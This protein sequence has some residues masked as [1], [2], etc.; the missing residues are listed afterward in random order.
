MY[1]EQFQKKAQK[2]FENDTTKLR[3][4]Y[5]LHK[6]GMSRPE[7]RKKL[8]TESIGAYSRLIETIE[9]GVPKASAKDLQRFINRH[10]KDFSA[11][12]IQKLERL[13]TECDRR[14]NKKSTKSKK[15]TSQAEEA[16]EKSDIAGIYVYTYPKYY[17]HP[18]VPETND[19]DA[20]IYLKIGMSEKGAFK[21]VMQQKT[22]MPE[23]PKTLQIWK[24]END[25]D[26]RE[27]E[28]K[29]HDHLR[30]IGHGG[31]QRKEWF[32]T[33]E[34][35]VESIANLLGLRLHYKHNPEMDD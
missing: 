23:E 16:L 9:T 12:D 7:I 24:V 30:I 17:Y 34:D 4:V 22:G 25:G 19:T 26:L 2:A 10:R 3:K 5:G 15:E 8:N 27:M 1:N 20:R 31:H 33:N 28:R 21:R 6:N 32:L 11:V 29:I 18:D 14:A 35:S 13:A